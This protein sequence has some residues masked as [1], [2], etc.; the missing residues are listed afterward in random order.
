MLTRH[1]ILKELRRMGVK[2]P[3][4]LKAYLRDFENYIGTHYGLKIVK[5]KKKM[6]RVGIGR[7]LLQIYAG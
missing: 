5:T 1:D 2:D 3:S 7:G 4:L 6:E